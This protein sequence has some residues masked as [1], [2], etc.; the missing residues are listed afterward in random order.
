MTERDPF[1]GRKPRSF[2]RLSLAT[3]QMSG[4]VC[5]VN[6][7]RG[8]SLCGLPIIMS[9]NPGTGNEIW[10]R[11]GLR[12]L[13]WEFGPVYWPW[14]WGGQHG[15]TSHSAKVK[16]SGEK[17]KQQLFW[18]GY[19]QKMAIS[20]YQFFHGE[21]AAGESDFS[22][23]TSMFLSHWGLQRFPVWGRSWFSCWHKISVGRSHFVVVSA[24]RDAGMGGREGEEKE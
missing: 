11:N 21:K 5:A 23:L 10:C 22:S 19:Y 15:I 13:F 7:P 16:I 4:V 1:T 24:C 18:M 3:S 6:W 17:S 9:I 20:W 2:S 14:G 8:C 12:G